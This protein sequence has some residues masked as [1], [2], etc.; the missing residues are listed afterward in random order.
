MAHVSLYRGKSK[1]FG[2]VYFS[3]LEHAAKAIKEMDKSSIG[4]RI[5]TVELVQLIV[6]FT[7][8]GREKHSK[9]KKNKSRNGNLSR[10]ARAICAAAAKKG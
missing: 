7:H 8:C 10:C 4:G 9:S 6:F 2:F 3:S 5:I 1:G